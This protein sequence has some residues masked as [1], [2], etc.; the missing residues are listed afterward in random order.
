M[1]EELFSYD[2]NEIVRVLT[3]YYSTL[4]RA[5][6]FSPSDIQSPPSGGWTDSELDVD[7]LRALR[8]SDRVIDLLRHIPYVKPWKTGKEPI[9]WPV[10]V[11]S[12][13]IGYLRDGGDFKKWTARGAD[14]L[15]E[16]SGLPFD[17]IPAGPMDLPP[18]VVALT[19][20]YGTGPFGLPW[21]IIDCETGVLTSYEGGEGP[22]DK[23]WQT[24]KRSPQEYFDTMTRLLESAIHIALP[25]VKDMEPE[26]CYMN[27]DE[28]AGVRRYLQWIY[29]CCGW[30][31][32]KEDPAS[33]RREECCAKLK[34][35]RVRVQKA[36]AKKQAHE[37]SYDDP[38]D[39][40]YADTD[41]DNSET[42]C[43]ED[44]QGEEILEEG[45]EEARG[46]A[47]AE[48]VAEVWADLDEREYMLIDK[49]LGQKGVSHS[50]PRPLGTP[51][52]LLSVPG[53]TDNEGKADGQVAATRYPYNLSAVV[54]AINNYYK[55]L[56][57]AAYFP[58]SL[59]EYAPEHGWDEDAFPYAELKALGYSDKAIDLLRHLPYLDF[60][61]HCWEVFPGSFP[62]RYLRDADPF[63]G[64]PLERLKRE[65]LR[66]LGLSPYKELLP[67]NVVA[68]AIQ[69]RVSLRGTWWMVD[70]DRGTIFTKSHFSHGGEA[71]PGSRPGSDINAEPIV[72][73]FEKLASQLK[74]L[75]SVPMPA[76]GISEDWGPE[77]WAE[78]HWE[79]GASLLAKMSEADW[80]SLL[81]HRPGMGIKGA[82]D[83]YR[84]H[85][86]PDVN[87]FRRDQCVDELTELRRDTVYGN[88]AV[89]ESEG[90]EFGNSDAT[91]EEQSG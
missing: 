52:R 57:H 74:S 62:I 87:N 84:A 29:T 72:P 41:N 12:R 13:A 5:C 38:E 77:I 35:Y 58:P 61:E 8:R 91:M 15:S 67:P 17:E 36:E 90:N 88:D 43:Y 44:T 73:A 14:G 53:P 2:R 81:P 37:D 80:R 23:P 30:K 45:G 40:D 56:S 83:V 64:I 21:C 46:N 3:T 82:R 78:A 1:T 34:S 85:G 28:L 42:M 11:R 59:V 49:Q 19:R 54:S 26:I 66:K 55:L 47:L 69:N 25:P 71:I 16:L 10:L 22:A 18:D 32:S 27:G 33:W 79:S 48:E 50:I 31:F 7:A 24:S 51:E 20:G 65:S 76:F 89:E 60:D 9:Q 68:I 6:Y 75:E 70:T 39:S 63:C 4:A 86:W